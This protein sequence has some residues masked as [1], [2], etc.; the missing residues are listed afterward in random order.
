MRSQG[1]TLTAAERRAVA[2]FLSPQTAASEQPVRENACPGGPPPIANLNG[3]N[4]WGVDLVNSRLQ[5]T[6]AAGLRADD[7]PKLK[8]K[9][10]FGIPYEVTVEAQP[11]SSEAASFSAAATGLRLFA[12]RPH[13]LP[14]LDVQGRYPHAYGHQHRL[15]RR[16]PVCRILRRC[17]NQRLRRERANRKT[18]LE[19][20]ARSCIRWPASRARRNYI[21]GGFTSA[22][23]PLRRDGR[24]RSQISLLHFPRQSGRDRRR[25][26]QGGVEDIS[27]FPTRPRSTKMNSVGYAVIRTF[28]RR[29]LVLSH[30][31]RQAQSHLRRHR[32]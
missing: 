17:R 11:T 20:E 13:R 7:I 27:R 21:K 6:A 1:E 23:V 8:V 31:R 12:R 15:H 10:A 16:R 9:W 3:W 30:H 19:N 26:R 29:H 14:V 5:S 25:H 32:Q 4:G 22:C 24:R 2:D 18:D 28:R